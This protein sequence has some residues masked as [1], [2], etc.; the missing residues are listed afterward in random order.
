MDSVVLHDTDFL[1]TAYTAVSPLY[2]GHCAL[3]CARGGVT[4]ARVVFPTVL[5]ANAAASFAVGEL[6]GYDRADVYEASDE[7]PTHSKWMDWAF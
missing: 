1:G 2:S 7:T 5:D 4:R 3:E 6:G